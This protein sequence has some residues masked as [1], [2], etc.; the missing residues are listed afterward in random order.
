MIITTDPR[1]TEQP[2]AS[3]Y[4]NAN[5]IL[6]EFGA[7]YSSNLPLIFVCRTSVTLSVRLFVCSSVRLTFDRLKLTAVMIA[8]M[9][10][11][12]SSADFMIALVSKEFAVSCGKCQKCQKMPTK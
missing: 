5:A 2:L 7:A 9:L 1:A 3:S 12:I 11:K 6:C 4:A 10:E 8:F